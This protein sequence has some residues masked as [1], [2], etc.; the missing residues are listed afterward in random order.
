MKTKQFQP[1][2]D[3]AWLLLTLQLP[4]FATAWGSESSFE[5]GTPISDRT[6]P[7]LSAGT[8]TAEIAPVGELHVLDTTL[9]SGPS[10]GMNLQATAIAAAVGIG[11]GA[12]SYAIWVVL[13]EGAHALAVEAAGGDF[14]HFSFLPTVMEGGGVRFA[15][16]YWADPN[17]NIS[18]NEMGW[19]DIAPNV[20]GLAFGTVGTA[21][22]LADALPNSRLARMAFASFQIGASINGGVI[23]AW[24]SNPQND[25]PKAIQAFALNEDQALIFRA[26]LTTGAVINLIP[27]IDS[28]VYGLTGDSLVHPFDGAVTTSEIQIRPITAPNYLGVSGAF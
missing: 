13:H 9:T 20:T 8:N 24:S 14:S 23:S 27:A 19:I 22:W 7:A 17:G 21:L 16:T 1:G 12:L 4:T 15:A 5:I 11:T 10:S 26:A 2:A 6:G 3:K 28:I 18:Q 25:I